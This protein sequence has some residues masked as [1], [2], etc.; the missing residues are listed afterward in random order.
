MEV[1]RNAP[2]VRALPPILD[3]PTSLPVTPIVPH[4]MKASML[5][6]ISKYPASTPLRNPAVQSKYLISKLKGT[7]VYYQHMEGVMQKGANKEHVAQRKWDRD[8][9]EV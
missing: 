4:L 8:I 6:K 2:I 1:R 5:P 9:I 7:R 3:T